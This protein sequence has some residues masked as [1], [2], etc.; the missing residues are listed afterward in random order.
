MG[1]YGEEHRDSTSKHG[2]LDQRLEGLTYSYPTTIG[3]QGDLSIFIVSQ[4]EAEKV[5]LITN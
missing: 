1:F 3:V 2:F 4:K 5:H